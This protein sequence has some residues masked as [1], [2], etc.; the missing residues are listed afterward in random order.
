MYR[1]DTRRYSQGDI[2]YPN[3]NSYQDF[4]VDDV[5]KCI[6]NVLETG[7]SNTE[8]IGIRKKNLFIFQD[9]SD[10]LNFSLKKPDSKIYEVIKLSDTICFH[11]G[12]MNFTELIK[13]FS[14]QQDVAQTLAKMYWAGLK[15][16][17][18]CWEMIV[19]KIQV[20][21]IL[22]ADEKTRNCL[23]D[24]YQ[25]ASTIYHSNIEKL[26]FDYL[27]WYYSNNL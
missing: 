10:A 4:F 18:P 13:L 21:K 23:Y 8:K 16:G 15:T 12:D 24:K 27:Q 25:N 2:I 17:K 3:A 6:E 5:K 19:D 1:V 22:L 7:V 20:S 26:S 14:N 11:R 9:F